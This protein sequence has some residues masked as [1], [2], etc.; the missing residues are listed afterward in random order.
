[1]SSGFQRIV[2]VLAALLLPC[3]WLNGCGGDDALQSGPALTGNS[4]GDSD[5]SITD[6]QDPT[7]DGSG[8]DVLTP[9]DTLSTDDSLGA[10]DTNPIEIVD[11]VSSPVDATAGDAAVDGAADATLACPGQDGCPCASDADCTSLGACLDSA[12]GKVCAPPCLSGEPCPQDTACVPLPGAATD[13]SED[14]TVCAPKFVTNCDPCLDSKACAYLGGKSACVSTADQPGTDGWFCANSCINAGDCPSGWL[15]AD[16]TAVEGGKSGYCHPAGAGACACSPAAVALGKS[17][18]CASS[19]K[20][21]DGTVVLGCLG[22]RTCGTGGLSACSAPIAKPEICNGLDDDCNGLTDDAAP[23]DDGKLCTKDACIAGGC[24]FA[25]ADASPCD[26]SDPC[27]VDDACTGGKCAGTPKNCDDGNP[28]SADTCQGKGSCAHVD[29][30]DGAVCED[31]D[32]CTKADTCASGKCISGVNQCSCLVNADCAAFED[33]NACNGKLVCVGSGGSSFC[34]VDPTSIVT[35]SKANDTTCLHAVCDTADGVC[36]GVVQNNGKVCDDANACTNGELCADGACTG[37]S[38]NCDDANACTDDTCAIAT[39]CAHTP[40]AV[41]CSDANACTQGDVC[42]AGAC[43]TKAVVCD[44]EYACTADSCD[45]TVGCVFTAVAPADC[46]SST[47]PYLEPFNCGSTALQLWKKTPI[48]LDPIVKWAVD[49]TPAA[50]GF[51]SPDCSLNVNNG[52]DVTCPMQQAT[53]ESTADSP[54]INATSVAPGAPLVLRFGSAGSWKQQQADVFIREV[55][56]DWQKVL[57]VAAGPGWQTQTVVLTAYAAKSFQVRFHFAGNCGPAGAVGWFVDDVLVAVDPCQSNNGGCGA[58]KLCTMGGDGQASCGSCQPGFSV[59]NGACADIDECAVPAS[60]GANAICVNKPGT[61][62]CTCKAGY[63]GDGKTCTDIDECAANLD[64]CAVTAACFNLPGSFQCTCPK[65]QFGDG[66]T[67]VDKGGSGSYPATSCLEI[68]TLYPASADGVYWLDIDGA[69]PLP[70][71]QY[72]CDM[73]NG[74]WT[75]VI[76]D[77]FENSSNAGWSAGTVSTCGKFGHILGGANQFGQGAVT[78]KTVSTPPHTQAKLWAHY[79]RIDQWWFNNGMVGIDG[80]KVW[81][82]QGTG[83]LIFNGSHECG[84]GAWTDEEW[85]PTWQGA[86][87]GAAITFSAWSDV[88][89]G[90]DSTSF[91]VDDVYVWVM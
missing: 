25:P 73:K 26:D 18:S 58:D 85:N 30:E 35:C 36:K 86:H 74:G 49:G 55:G 70:A 79:I 62:Q 3:L 34:K 63:Q 67:C 60:C 61:Y 83:D 20:L 51:E 45:P 69:G 24:V 6:G 52:I 66:L 4:N 57:D 13:G 10:N 41:P 71:S 43:T 7:G 44:D 32:A 12:Q 1:M 76:A 28:C 37:A 8:G 80:V 89:S 16:A 11:D 77:N 42:A 72:A 78:K 65:N 88:G 91:G 90:A 19:G 68:K 87:S 39:G 14:K 82:K 23:C 22:Q 38:I 9:D 84:K 17:T 31:G 2:T 48:S 75:L 64:N 27:T 81:S 29:L 50:P 40:N 33:G 21:P 46:P 54:V 5:I 47:V 15:C 56:G 53:I 59:Q